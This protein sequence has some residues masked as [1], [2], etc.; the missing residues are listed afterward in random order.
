MRL[1][2]L[3]ISLFHF[4]NTTIL[5]LLNNEAHDILMKS[6]WCNLFISGA[7]CYGEKNQALKP[8]VKKKLSCMH[9]G[10]IISSLLFSFNS[11]F[12]KLPSKPVHCS[13]L[14][15]TQPLYLFPTSTLLLAPN[16][17]LST[18]TISIP[19]V[20]SKLSKKKENCLLLLSG[21][22]I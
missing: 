16:L 1:L 20:A 11:T 21:M 2:S 15:H 8:S 5:Y 18:T 9:N 13:C 3:L 14:N 12:T 4:H 17:P 6:S 10:N 7:F 22:F 19:R